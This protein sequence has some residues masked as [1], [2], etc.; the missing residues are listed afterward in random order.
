MNQKYTLFIYWLIN[1]LK[2]V[3][4]LIGIIVSVIFITSIEAQPVEGVVTKVNKSNG[5]LSLK[6]ASKETMECF[7][8]A[9]DSQL[10]YLTKR[11]QG[12]L[13]ESNGAYYL[14]YIW[15]I[16]PDHQAQ[17]KNAKSA[18]FAESLKRGSNPIRKIGEN[19]PAFALYNQN[20]ELMTPEDFAGQIIVMTFVFTRCSNP[21]MCPANL[22][23]M[24][25]LQRD[26]EASG[27]K[28]LRL[29]ILSFDP[30]YD[31][32]GILNE[33]AQSHKINTSNFTLLTGDKEMV[34]ELMLQ[35]GV[36]IIPSQETYTHTSTAMIIDKKGQI[37]YRQTGFRWNGKDF[38]EKVI[39]LQ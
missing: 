34:D 1:K 30:E 3:P 14:E 38:L 19:L 6:L 7:V 31:S 35:F 4:L 5:T 11:I 39:E 20:A 21:K 28:N 33:Y 29:V 15:P 17:I 22:A 25:R 10:N 8:N 12:E 36:F 16:N 13:C 24:I 27:V 26:A 37:A 2:R 18:L 9:G 23:R 32:P